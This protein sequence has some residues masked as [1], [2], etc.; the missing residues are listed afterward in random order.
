MVASGQHFDVVVVGAGLGGLGAATTLADAGRRVLVLEHAHQPGGYA[1]TFDRPPF[2]FDASLHALGGLAPGGGT[3]ALLKQLGVLDQLTL[4]RLD[5]FYLVRAPAGDLSVPADFFAYE[6]TLVGMFPAERRGIRAWFDDCRNVVAEFR[7]V[8][9]DQSA[10]DAPLMQ[11]WPG[12]YP[13]IARL[14]PQTWAQATEAHVSDPVL[15]SLLTVLW[16]YAATPPSRLSA[17]VGMAIVGSY[18][19]FGGWYP[20]GGA[21]AIPR[22]L[23]ARLASAGVPIEYG[24]TVTALPVRDGKVGSVVTEQG[25]EVTCDAVVSNAGGRPL[26]D[27]VGSEQLPDEWRERVTSPTI[28]WSNVSVFLGLGRD[29]FAEQALPHEVFLAGSGDADTD[30]AAGLAGDWANTTIMATDC[31]HLD[32]GCAPA[33]GGV[34]VLAA[35]AAYDY[36]HTWGTKGGE[37]TS[38][39]VK[40]RVADALVTIADKAIPGLASA[41]L[42]REVASPVTNYRYTLNPGGSWAGHETTPQSG[43]GLGPST[44]I[45][46]LFQ[47]GAWT[48]SFGQTPALASGVA[49]GGQ[50]INY[51]TGDVTSQA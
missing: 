46:N 19:L 5:P 7:R 12:E 13:T 51:L 27:L 20:H 34:V 35:G 8:E 50:V 36:A 38:E 14:T 42:Q 49:A 26:V 28:A 23:A 31:T 22:A 25:L 16:D 3:D 21:G 44:P 4:T 48:G 41:V 2:R 10:G 29:V 6:Q 11:D 9:F 37:E 47:A 24:Q 1:V 45:P 33:G 30:F 39:Q 15:A 17:I 18:G 43:F 32:P 40:D